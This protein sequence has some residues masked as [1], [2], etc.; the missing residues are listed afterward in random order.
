MES[1]ELVAGFTS[2]VR[3]DPS[4]RWQLPSTAWSCLA[5]IFDPATSAAT[6]CSSRIFQV[7]N[8]SMSG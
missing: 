5:Q 3:V 1:C 4:P 6:F 2:V 8:S 7:T